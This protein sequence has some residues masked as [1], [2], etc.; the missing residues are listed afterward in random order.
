[1]QRRAR[2]SAQPLGAM[3]SAIA[4]LLSALA[5]ATPLAAQD[6]DEV[7]IGDSVDFGFTVAVYVDASRHLRLEMQKAV[8]HAVNG[9]TI[10]CARSSCSWV[11]QTDQVRY[12]I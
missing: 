5:A 8:A 2:R 9:G 6:D 1:M 12:F 4:I 11:V 7:L 10:K 3:H